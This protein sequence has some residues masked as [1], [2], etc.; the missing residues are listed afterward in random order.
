METDYMDTSIDNTMSETTDSDNMELESDSTDYE[1]SEKDTKD[2]ESSE[3]ETFDWET[4][5]WDN[6]ILD[7]EAIIQTS[8]KC[9]YNIKTLFEVMVSEGC[10]PLLH[11]NTSC[12]KSRGLNRYLRKKIKA[13]FLSKF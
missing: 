11:S 1:T 4:F 9:N 12:H 6:D 13:L 8:A 10:I 2:S 7:S 5:D 3:T